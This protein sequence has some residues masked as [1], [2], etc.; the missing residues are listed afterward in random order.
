MS[1]DQA[2]MEKQAQQEEEKLQRKI[3]TLSDSD[4]REIYEKGQYGASLVKLLETLC[5][6]QHHF[7][8]LQV[9]SC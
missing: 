4:R 6:Q 1:P 3:Q 5:I 8:L 2:Y 9:W 7:L